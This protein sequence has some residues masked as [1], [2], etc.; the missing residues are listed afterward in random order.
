MHNHTDCICL[1]FL[2]CAFSNV[3]SKR[4]HEMMKNHTGCI[5]LTFPCVYWQLFHWNSSAWNYHA[6]GFLP[7]STCGMVCPLLP[8]VL[9]WENSNVKIARKKESESN[10]WNEISLPHLYAMK[11]V[12][13]L[14]HLRWEWTMTIMMSQAK[15]KF[16]C[17]DLFLLPIYMLM[18]MLMVSELATLGSAR[19]LWGLL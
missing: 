8:L 9:N 2:H 7:S 12:S 15:Y 4:L 10:C 17:G 18:M 5:W 11:I 1:T 14:V 3:S 16:I 19:D 6:Q 13:L